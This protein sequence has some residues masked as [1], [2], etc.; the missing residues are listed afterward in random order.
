[1]AIEHLEHSAV[2][3]DQQALACMFFYQGVDTGECAFVESRQ[4]FAASER[5]IGLLRPEARV[6]LRHAVLRFR[7]G[8]ALERAVMPLAEIRVE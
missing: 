5:E 6:L 7:I 2:G 3:E 1:M 4:R 8:H